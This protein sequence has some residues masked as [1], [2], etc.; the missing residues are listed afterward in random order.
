MT[1]D[2]PRTASTSFVGLPFSANTITFTYHPLFELFFH[3]SY[4]KTTTL[5][6]SLLPNFIPF[7]SPFSRNCSLCPILF[8]PPSTYYFFAFSPFSNNF[9]SSVRLFPNFFSRSQPL[10]LPS[11]LLHY[12]YPLLSSFSLTFSLFISLFAP[13]LNHLFLFIF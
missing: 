11:P 7:L 3:R 2:K 4:M 13:S 9:L 12:F 10:L 8:P 6:F 1:F 5:S